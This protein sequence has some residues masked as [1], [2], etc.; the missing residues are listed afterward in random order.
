M[1]TQ[2]IGVLF[3]VVIG[4]QAVAEDEGG[5][6]VIGGMAGGVAALGLHLVAEVAD[7]AAVELEGKVGDVGGPQLGEALP[8]AVEQRLPLAGI[9]AEHLGERAA[10]V[11]HEGEAAP[12]PGPAAVEPERVLARSIYRDECS[13]WIRERID[14]LHRADWCE[15][16]VSLLS[17]YARQKATRP[18][19]NKASGRG[20][21]RGAACRARS[22]STRGGTGPP[23]AGDC[24]V[25][26]PSAPRR[27]WLSGAAPRAAAS[28]GRASGSGSPETGLGCRR[29]DRS[30][31]AR[32]RRPGRASAPALAPPVRPQPSRS[33]AG[34]GR[35]RAGGARRSGLHRRRRRSRRR[36][37]DARGRARS[38]RCRTPVVPAPAS[39]P[40]RFG[41]QVGSVPL[42]SASSW[43]RL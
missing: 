35:P 20:S 11:A 8:E 28:P 19:G 39:S 15:I 38:R 3:L 2:E 1:Q 36:D 40:R 43:K 32:R 7:E 29:R 42:T 10:G 33:P 6:W 16:P 9:V 27:R 41:P 26:M 22:R 37:R 34:R 25:R 18:S 5:V 4:D 13:L 14:P 30:H 31:R 24:G 12:G 23:T 17:L 21:W